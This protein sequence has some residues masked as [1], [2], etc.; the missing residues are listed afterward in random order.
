MD[1]LR[2]MAV[3]VAVAEE[4]GFAAAARRLQMSPPAVTKAIAELEARLGIKLLNRTTRFVRATEAGHRYLEDVRRILADVDAADETAAGINATPSGELSV[5]A[6]MLFGKKFVLPGV[7]DYLNRFPETRVSAVFLDRIVNLLQEGFDVGVRIGELPDSS[8]RALRVGAVR[9][10]V[11]GSPLYLKK[12]GI[13]THLEALHDHTL[14][15]VSAGSG[16]QAWRFSADGET[17]PLRIRP[18]LTVTSS[19]AAVSAAVLGFGLSRLLSYQVAS[20]ISSGA[21]QLVLADFEPPPKPVHIIHREGLV[22]SAKVR[23]FVDLM[24]DRLREDLAFKPMT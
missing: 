4:E 21:L 15:T 5:T 16:S 24:S 10:V 17:R 2:T 8:I 18:R 19:D 11:V 12:F 9:T 23:A 1:R 7:V 13:P 22:Q 14:V 20:E 6:P 3:F